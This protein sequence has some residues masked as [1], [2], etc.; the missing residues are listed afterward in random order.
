MKVVVAPDSFKG[1]LAAPDVA[2]ALADG[3]RKV[4]PDADVELLPLSDGGEGW[5]DSLVRAASGKFETARV[6][7]P[8]GDP[9][10]ARFGLIETD[11]GVTGVIEMAA[12]SGL[13]LLGRDE[14][15]P[16]RT[17]TYGTGELMLRAL[18]HGA[19]RLLI[20]VGG[21]ATNDGGAGMAA[22]LGARLLDDGGEELEPGGGALA[23]LARVD[24][25]GLDGRVGE[26]EILVGVDVDNPLTGDEGASAV[27][28]PQKGASA[29]MVE[30]LDSALTRLADVVEKEL[31]RP[32]RS[33]PGAGAAGGLGF[34]LMAFCEARLQP[35][36][37]LALEAVGADAVVE[38]AALVITAEGSLDAQTLSGKV[39]VGVA[40]LAKRHGV[41]TVAVGGVLEPMEDQT[42]QRFYEVGVAVLC[43]SME[44][45]A[46][47]DELVDPGQTR[48]RLARTSE[49]IARLIELGGAVRRPS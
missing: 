20:G 11:A 36:I 28:G 13:A 26:A 43:S 2:Q 42:L 41:G 33:V 48:A 18:E 35:G 7:G 49:R 30:E 46:S 44:T 10:D 9:V 17:T 40:R 3:L 29:D 8:L 4:W 32:L 34:G 47:I 16:R 25:H 24:L 19:G 15:D 23:R 45:E 5:V 37:D 22:A 31:G 38:G 39:P 27:Y 6:K 21:S 14:R 1:S 12:A